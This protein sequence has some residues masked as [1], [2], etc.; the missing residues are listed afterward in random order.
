MRDLTEVMKRFLYPYLDSVYMS[1]NICK[2]FISLSILLTYPA[3][4][5]IQ[6][7]LCDTIDGYLAIVMRHLR[8]TLIFLK[9][10]YYLKIKGNNLP[11]HTAD[12]R[13]EFGISSKTVPE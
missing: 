3:V 8:V 1:V 6:P 12:H 13:G 4:C 10:N 5:R 2:N 11:K 7:H 9:L